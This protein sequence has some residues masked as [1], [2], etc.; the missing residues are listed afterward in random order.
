MIKQ[1]LKGVSWN[2][3]DKLI[4]QLVYFF[5]TIYI[6][7]VIGPADFGMIGLLMVFVLLV[8]TTLNNGFSQALIQKNNNATNEDFSTIFICGVILGLLFY[9]LLYNLLPF[10]SKLVN[11]HELIQAGRILLVVVIFNSFTVVPRAKLIIKLNF[12]TIAII[13]SFSGLVATLLAVL[14]INLG[15][16]YWALVLQVLTKS[17]FSVLLF[18]LLKKSYFR[19][20]FSMESLK[21]L[22]G[23]GIYIMLSS[24][25]AF[26]SNNLYLFIVTKNINFTSAGYLS[27][28]NSQTNMLSGL[29][30]SVLQG[31]IF[32]VFSS[33]KTDINLLKE[34]YLRIL[35][36]TFLISFPLL[37]GFAAIAKPFTLLF[38]GNDWEGIIFLIVILSFARVVTPINSLNL[39]LI[40]AIGKANL[41]FKIEIIKFPLTI[42][43]IL[44]SISF[45]LN[46]VV[47]ALLITSY[48]SFFINAYYFGKILGINAYTQLKIGLIPILSSFMMFSIC[49]YLS[50]YINDFLSL[51]ILI[52]MGILFYL[53]SMYFLGGKLYIS[54]VIKLFK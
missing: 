31:V 37:L 41:T 5:V 54:K 33:V 28:A 51:V 22:L 27:Q 34:I 17:I 29:V 18:I 44:L 7:K 12:K 48:L 42:S 3:F 39:S 13:N 2:L 1:F 30:S 21:E 26:I 11:K 15:F 10:L 24:I 45:G 36:I 38:L 40:N 52:L 25:I 4:N 9:L 8:E 32:P 35:E 20:K 6:A 43:S 16:G 19:L 14:A 23:F 49:F 50:Q 47:I 53:I 46:A